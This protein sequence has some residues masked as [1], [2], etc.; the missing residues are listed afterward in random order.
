MIRVPKSSQLLEEEARVVG[1][2][3]TSMGHPSEKALIRLLG[4]H[5]VRPGV[6][7]AVRGIDCEYC[8]RNKGPDPPHQVSMPRLSSGSFGDEL[9][10]DIFFFVLP[11]THEAVPILG[12]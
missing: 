5:R 12:I 7:D 4:Q 8:K 3:H 11:S 9:S 10:A 2:L 6:L 1:R